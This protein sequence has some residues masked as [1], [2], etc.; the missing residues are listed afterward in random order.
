MH[1][2]ISR[3][4]SNGYGY[5]LSF[6]LKAKLC[7]QSKI[8]EIIDLMSQLNSFSDI[9]KYY[10]QSTTKAKDL[11]IDS[12]QTI[13]VWRLDYKPNSLAQAH[14][15][16]AFCGAVLL[17]KNFEINDGQTV[18]DLIEPVRLDLLKKWRTGKLDLLTRT[19]DYVAYNQTERHMRTIAYGEVCNSLSEIVELQKALLPA[20]RVIAGDPQTE[21]SIDSD[22][23]TVVNLQVFS[24]D[25]TNSSRQQHGAHSDRVDT[26]AVVPIENIGPHGELVFID[27][28]AQS[29]EQ[30]QLD[31]HQDFNQNLTKILELAPKSIRFRVHTTLPGNIVLARTD[32]DIHFISS[33]SSED[34][35]TNISTEQ[36][37]QVQN[38]EFVLGRGIINMAF[39]T[40]RC[41]DIDQIA[42]KIE[43]EASFTATN[44]DYKA[45][46][47]QLDDA[48][49]QANLDP[50][51]KEAV[52]GAIITR[53][54]AQDLYGED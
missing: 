8:Y 45:F 46:F 44:H 19:K 20:V 1:I 31:Q 47:Q 15:C 41:R 52:R 48:L 29:C 27:N 38:G 28:Y 5:I 26:T 40:K 21:I 49:N 16:F 51:I 23:G 10:S 6:S 32:K 12:D 35:L 39:E 50:E 14:E 13:E 33:K 9:S 34:V 37:E 30:L 2:S 53:I 22:E 42:H 4:R 36:L 43:N 11:D 7:Y 3:P 18:G 25:N 17:T 24:K 54:S